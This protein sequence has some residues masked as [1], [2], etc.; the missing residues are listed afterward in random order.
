MFE[1]IF[2]FVNYSLFT[3]ILIMSMD[4]LGKILGFEQMEELGISMVLAQYIC[5]C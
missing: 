3:F 5:S 2:T 4:N 1:R